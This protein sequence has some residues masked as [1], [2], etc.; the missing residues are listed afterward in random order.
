MPQPQPTPQPSANSYDYSLGTPSTRSNADNRLRDLRQAGGILE[1][2]QDLG[3]R[4]SPADSCTISIDFTKPG[5]PV[6]TY[7]PTSTQIPTTSL[8]VATTDTGVAALWDSG[9]SGKNVKVA[10]VDDFFGSTLPGG[11]PGVVTHGDSTR[12]I[13]AQMAPEADIGIQNISLIFSGSGNQ[14]IRE[15]DN[16]AKGAYDAL[17]TS[18][19]FI[20]NSSFAYDPYRR[21]S[22]GVQIDQNVFDGYVTTQLTQPG[23][24]KMMRPAADSNSYDEKML[25]VLSAG[26]SG[27]KC[28][29]GI[30]QCRISARALVELRKTETDA[31]DR[32]IYVGALEDGQNVMASYSFV[33]GKLKNDFIVAHDN[34]W[35]PGDAKGTSFSTPRVTGAA[36]LLRHKFP[37]LDGP[38]L[39]QVILQT[40]D[41][42]GATGVDEVFGHGK[43]N[44]PNA[45]S[46]I[47]KVTPR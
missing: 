18:S 24:L 2:F 28:S 1:K 12:A 26:N 17:E 32:V 8:P 23:F 27:S 43:L 11:A 38:A 15:L 7:C 45:M 6:A 47:G 41:D 9:W 30:D 40:A 39:K 13:V 5:A 29:T 44:V 42:L 4:P 10:L 46:P 31:G 20:V 14:I 25:F 36:T 21:L 3:S 35:Q 22:V 16:R 19:H 37:N 34:V 33:A